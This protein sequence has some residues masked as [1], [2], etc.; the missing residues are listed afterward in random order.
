MDWITFCMQKIINDNEIIFNHWMLTFI[1]WNCIELILFFGLFIGVLVSS[2]RIP[3][4]TSH[5]WIQFVPQWWPVREG[6]ILIESNNVSPISNSEM[7][8]VEILK[9]FLFSKNFRIIEPR[10]QEVSDKKHP[11]L[12][13]NPCFLYNFNDIIN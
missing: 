13:K 3:N 10:S 12:Q 7:T 4:S 8:K 2:K 6:I 1:S 9:L 5:F 11:H